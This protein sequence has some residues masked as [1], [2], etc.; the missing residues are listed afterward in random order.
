[1]PDNHHPTSAPAFDRLFA[2]LRQHRR[3]R[4]VLRGLLA[5]LT[6]G[7]LCTLA[8]VLWMSLSHF[9]EAS[10]DIG[11]YAVYASLSLLLGLLVVW[12]ALKR[13]DDMQCALQTERQTP[14]LDGLL[15]SAVAMRRRDREAN[16]SNDTSAELANDVLRR[17]VRAGEKSYRLT[18]L[19]DRASLRIAGTVLA[20]FAALAISVNFG[21]PWLQ[22]GLR[23]LVTP[24]GDPAAAD[25]PFY[26][27]VSPGDA[28]SSA[29]EDQLI[30][31]SA[32]GFAP[33]TVTLFHRKVGEQQWQQLPMQGDREDF[34]GYIRAITQPLEYF[35][36]SG[37]ARSPNYHIDVIVKPTLE[38]IDVTYHY[39]QYT[40]RAPHTVRDSGDIRAPRGTEVEIQ[41]L[42]SNAPEGGRLVLDGDTHNDL[43]SDGKDAYRSAMTVQSNGRYRVELETESGQLVA[44][45]P[46][47]SIEAL[48]DALPSVALRSP[49]RDAQVS[50][51][52]EVDVAVDVADDFGVQ[53][54]EL[55]LSVNGGEE[56][57]VSFATAGSA[58]KFQAVKTL[59][60]E[61]RELQPGDLIAYYARARDAV[62]KTSRPEVVTDIFFMEVRPFEREY[63]AG[64]QSGGG[65]GGSGQ[66]QEQLAAQ[67]RMLVVALYNAVR[68]QN[69]VSADEYRVKLDKIADAQTRIRAR[70]DAI[71]RRLQAR[72]IL[73]LDPGYRQMAL[74]LPK[75]SQAM[76]DVENELQTGEGSA[77]QTPAR[78]ALLHL[79]RAEAAFRSVRVT[80]GDARGN[81]SGD[82]RNLFRLEMDRFRNQ[83]ADVRR[84]KWQADAERIDKTLEELRELARRQQRE[85]ERARLRS[86]RGDGDGGQSQRR[87]AEEVERMARELQRLSLQDPE[88]RGLADRLRRAA[89]SM[90]AAAAGNGIADSQEALRQLREA[91]RQLRASGPRRL[92]R[93]IEQAASE[94]RSLQREHDNINNQREPAAQTDAEAR[95][96][97]SERKR[98]MQD[99][100][101]K[102]REQMRRLTQTAEDR[103]SVREKLTSAGR[104]LDEHR[105]AENIEHTR[106]LLEESLPTDQDAE[107]AIGEG[108]R[109]TG[110]RLDA[111]A[112]GVENSDGERI[113]QAREQLRDVV[114]GLAGMSPGRTP[115]GFG[116]GNGGRRGR[117]P[118]DPVNLR[119]ALRAHAGALRDLRGG[120][121]SRPKAV[122]NVD[123][124]IAGLTE[125]AEDLQDDDQSATRHAQ[126][127]EALQNL[128]YALRDGI[129]GPQ[130]P[131]QVFAPRHV[132]PGDEHREIVEAYYR[133]LSESAPH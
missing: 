23:L 100:L 103:E 82:L 78:T 65:G 133:A 41:L 88:L 4:Q 54:L 83:Y 22:H 98:A 50:S 64:D 33:Q 86:Q 104:T 18:R 61:D 72:G 79:Q 68:D 70:V 24:L 101:K 58:A 76:Q 20:L 62:A 63:R 40:G 28:Q 115:N 123:E 127:L 47:F 8:I 15:L 122:G 95:Q 36:L 118:G 1:M 128:D 59:Y 46:E 55:V 60:L 109:A 106:R 121:V 125:L 91:R 12:P 57:T 69:K 32:R 124:V 53:E 16:A 34:T 117:L 30:I 51:L 52:E 42:V 29:G 129:A 31:A 107:D 3:L 73:Q 5:A 102:L 27:E 19:D 21:P 131:E 108:L 7:A 66:Q 99:R 119:D 17:T 67:Q 77:A 120:L 71:V 97:L 93:D 94:A 112:A 37:G 132:Q 126:L 96:A 84:G 13:V 11:R 6:V 45:S 80:R 92:A 25:N 9:E 56:E 35:V 81:N 44:V 75:A 113:A 48:E 39:P 87:L 130:E 90:R 26:F 43:Q 38:R 10:V 89:E 2:R 114:R 111:A 49:G 105:V 14:Q 116:G 110:E 74:E 85:M